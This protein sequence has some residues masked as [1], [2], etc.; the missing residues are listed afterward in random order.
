MAG[1]DRTV[2]SRGESSRYLDRNRTKTRMPEKHRKKIWVVLES[3]LS[4]S[5]V[6]M[7]GSDSGC[8]GDCEDGG[9]GGLEGVMQIPF[10]L[11]PQVGD[12]DVM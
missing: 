10:G 5:S 3:R 9:D 11:Y 6:A 4:S 7:M 1:S 2:L 12:D 8:D